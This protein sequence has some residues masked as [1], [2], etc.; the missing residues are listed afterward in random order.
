MTA[1]ISRFV[2]NVGVIRSVSKHRTGSSGLFILPQMTVYKVLLYAYSPY[3]SEPMA[4]DLFL[5]VSCGAD[6]GARLPAFP[7]KAIAI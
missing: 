6:R 1:A 7:A 4:S 2:L 3:G 5:F